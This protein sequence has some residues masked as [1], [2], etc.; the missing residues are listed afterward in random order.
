MVLI[1]IPSC[2]GEHALIIAARDGHVEL[3]KELLDNG[4]E[5]DGENKVCWI[6]FLHQ[7]FQFSSC[8]F[9]FHDLNLML[10]VD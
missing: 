4:A 2:Q 8:S 5:V 3:A 7:V 10:T 1:A 9:L 6:F